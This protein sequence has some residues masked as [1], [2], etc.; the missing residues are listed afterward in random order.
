MAIRTH[1]VEPS[2]LRWYHYKHLFMG[3][4]QIDSHVVPCTEWTN[5]CRMS[6]SPILAVRSYN[7]PW[8]VFRSP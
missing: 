5:E 6:S 4:H 7:R 3:H 2:W 8:A 1:A